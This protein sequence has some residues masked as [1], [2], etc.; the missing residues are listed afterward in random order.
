MKSRKGSARFIYGL[1]AL[2]AFLS[3]S[4][5]VLVTLGPVPWLAGSIVVTMVLVSEVRHATKK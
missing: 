2:I 1:L 5:N 4:G 3:W